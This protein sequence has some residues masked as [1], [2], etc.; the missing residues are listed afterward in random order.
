MCKMKNIFQCLVKVG[1]VC[2]MRGHLSKGE[3]IVST[4]H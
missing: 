4:Y 3:I 1:A 2:L